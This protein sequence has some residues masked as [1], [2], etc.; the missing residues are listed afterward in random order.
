MKNTYSL[1]ITE[2]KTYAL[3]W[4]FSDNAN[5]T[6]FYKHLNFSLQNEI[7]INL[8]NQFCKGKLLFK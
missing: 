3:N 2:V 7:Q 8:Y 5:K 4:P 1:L 6:R